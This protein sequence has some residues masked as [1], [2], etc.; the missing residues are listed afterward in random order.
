LARRNQKVKGIALRRTSTVL[1][2]DVHD[3]GT[4][5]ATDKVLAAVRELTDKPIRFI[6]DTAADPEI[7]GGNEAL[8]KTGASGGRGQAAGAGIIA[9][10]G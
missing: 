6:L 5:K 9:H 7:I 2:D 3:A 1:L 8:A 4:G 10:E